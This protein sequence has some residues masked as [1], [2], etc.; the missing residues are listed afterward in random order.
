MAK[1]TLL[2]LNTIFQEVFDDPQ[3]QV[4]PGTSSSDLVDWDSV[5]QVK[6]VLSIEDRFGIRLTSDELSTMHTVG[7]FMTAIA[8][9]KG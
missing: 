2:Q 1:S 4:E 3:L 7:D 5:A 9:Y 6:L 8:K